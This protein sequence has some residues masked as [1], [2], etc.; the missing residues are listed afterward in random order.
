MNKTKIEYLDYTWNP[1][2]MRC[3]PISA[4]CVNCWHLRMCDRLAA[5]PRI[6]HTLREAYAGEFP[7]TCVDS[8]LYEPEKRKKAAVIGAQFM[9]DPFHGE[10]PDY[11]IELVWRTMRESL[12]HTFL[13]LTKRAT[14]MQNLSYRFTRTVLFGDE[15]ALPNVWMGVTI[16]SLNEI[17]R[18]R[19]LVATQ[20]A[21]KFV[22]FEPLLSEI[23]VPPA[24]LREIDLVIVGCE[25]G[26]GRRSASRQWIRSLR[27]QCLAL[28]DDRPAFFLKQMDVDGKVASLPELDGKVW[29]EWP[30]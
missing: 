10:V 18:L 6:D 28:G 13:L 3:T 17:G 25:S 19:D 30:E 11:Y 2:A 7:P 9:G 1:I 21:K 12:Q 15:R 4:G 23:V 5:N 29:Q 22:S 20:A 27:D 26:P 8:R 24:L 16:E 14:R